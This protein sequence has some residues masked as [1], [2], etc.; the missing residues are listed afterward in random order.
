MSTVLILL[1]SLTDTRLLVS[2]LFRRRFVIGYDDRLKEV[3]ATDTQSSTATTMSFEN[4]KDRRNTTVYCY[5]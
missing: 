1:P 4:L 2:E 3:N 5:F